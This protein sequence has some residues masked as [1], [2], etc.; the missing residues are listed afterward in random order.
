MPMTAPPFAPSLLRLLGAAA[1]AALALPGMPAQAETPAPET[2]SKPAGPACDMAA[3][4]AG[5]VA[6]GGP[7]GELVLAD[8]TSLRPADL[9]IEGESAILPEGT[10]V[11]YR[12]AARAAD[13]W[14]R[15]PA[16]IMTASGGWLERGLVAQGR[17]LV[18]PETGEAGCIATLL[19][20]ETQARAASQGL[21]AD[22]SRPLAA[23]NLAKLLPKLGTYVV[24]EG[25]VRSVGVRQ[26]QTY[27]NFG[28]RWS[29]NLAVAMTKTLWT[30]AAA[31]SITAP[32]LEGRRV[33]VRGVLE[34]GSGPFIR[35]G[36]LDEIELLGDR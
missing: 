36:R 19:A 27:L 28:H 20:A 16:R 34:S 17:A 22:G 32:V 18:R 6:R 30:Q 5:I 26:R 35:I 4:L 14:G 15:W 25:L 1:L 13:R 7:H 12:R 3:P 23:D 33:R 31:R 29:E 21:W 24:A 11:T 10:P 8:D 2:Q 9:W